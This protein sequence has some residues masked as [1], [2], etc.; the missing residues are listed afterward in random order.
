MIIEGT[1]QMQLEASS[2]NNA[3]ELEVMQ[4]KYQSP[5]QGM[6]EIEEKHD[7]F[8]TTDTEDWMYQQPFPTPDFLVEFLDRLKFNHLFVICNNL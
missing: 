2:R 3:W 4:V 5:L 6:T 8:G 1:S 7:L